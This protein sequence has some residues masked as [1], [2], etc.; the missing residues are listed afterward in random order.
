MIPFSSRSLSG[1]FPSAYPGADTFCPLPFGL[2]W[3]LAG[4]GSG[5]LQGRHSFSCTAVWF[6]KDMWHC[7][8]CLAQTW[9]SL[10]YKSTALCC[11]FSEPPLALVQFTLGCHESS[12]CWCWLENKGAL[13]ALCPQSL[14]FQV[15]LTVIPVGSFISAGWK[16]AE[17]TGTLSAN[18]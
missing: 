9:Q 8:M 16:L 12:C 6:F 5:S 4:P 3:G 2:K 17:Q 11:W 14:P 18:Q 10:T 7:P 1:C 13:S 15:S